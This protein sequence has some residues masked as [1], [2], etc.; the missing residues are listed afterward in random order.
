MDYGK[1]SNAKKAM[2]NLPKATQETLR[3]K[4]K[5]HNEEFG[6]NAKKKL[7]NINYLA[8][9]YHRGIG[10]YNTNPSSVSSHC[11]LCPTVGYGQ[12]KWSFICFKKSKVQA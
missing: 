9:S 4:G 3:K 11:N 8:V 2:D 7:T 10:A 1:K 5:E 12:S 6:K